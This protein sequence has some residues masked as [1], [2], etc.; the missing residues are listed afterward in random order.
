MAGRYY[1]CQG[2]TL[3]GPQVITSMATAYETSAGSLADRLLAALVAGDCGGGD[4]RG[5]LAAAIVVAK[6]GV[7]GA[8]L[9]LRVDDSDDAVIELAQK[10]AAL[11]H[12]AKGPLYPADKPWMHPCAERPVP[13]PPQ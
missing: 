4:H 7:D 9:E 10:Y 11:I 2:N 8:W 13:K 3:V 5:R 12:D 6:K 1:S